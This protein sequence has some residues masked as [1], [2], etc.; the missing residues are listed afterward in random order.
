LI[1]VRKYH[2]LVIHTKRVFD[3]DPDVQPLIRLIAAEMPQEV[4]GGRYMAMLTYREEV[5]MIVLNQEL[6][7][8]MVE[9]C[10]A[11]DT[12]AEKCDTISKGYG[13]G[14]LSYE[15]YEIILH[16]ESAAIVLLGPNIMVEQQ[17]E[18]VP[19]E[20]A[21]LHQDFCSKDSESLLHTTMPAGDQVKTLGMVEFPADT[22]ECNSL[23]LRNGHHMLLNF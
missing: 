6:G 10:L 5:A 18:S 20:M 3:A 8:R 15:N 14:D 7:R 13:F 22:S 19:T 1:G 4:S 12:A 16:L 2:G 23:T 11:A 17:A 9:V 21:E